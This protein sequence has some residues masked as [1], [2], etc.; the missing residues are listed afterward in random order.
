[1]EGLRAFH[2]ETPRKV[3]KMRRE[4]PL[5]YPGGKARLGPFF[6]EL[7]NTNGLQD[8]IYIE[9]YAG[10]AGVAIYLLLGEFVSSIYIND[11]DEAV[12][13]FWKAILDHTEEFCSLI[14]N[15]PITIQEWDRQKTILA[16]GMN[17]VG[18]LET[19]FAMFFLNRTN[20]SGILN[21]GIIGGRKQ[22]GEWRIDARF[23]RGELIKRIQ[24]IS[25]YRGRIHVSNEDAIAFL[26]RITP[27]LQP[28][29]L[30]YLDPPYYVK[31]QHLYANF[32]R[33]DDHKNIAQFI[34]KIDLPW[35]IS[36]DDHSA[37]RAFYSNFR[38]SRYSLSYSARERRS[39][40]EVMF[41]SDRIVI[42]KST[43]KCDYLFPPVPRERH[44][45]K[46]F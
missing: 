45:N 3:N 44:K 40:T 11:V 15:V 4:T 10:G 8:G 14:E 29:S 16:E 43:L 32:Y 41:F 39:G 42:P 34:S 21:A 9:P 46:T 7:I 33:A 31:G 18:T 19:G 17:S 25:R 35:I 1:M 26:Q 37:I 12:Y 22:T 28:N 24:K 27:T 38:R 6:G 2:S 20:R 23:N 30:L 36:Y 13:S 5:R